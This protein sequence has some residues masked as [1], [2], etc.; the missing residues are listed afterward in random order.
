MRFKAKVCS[1]LFA[2]IAGLNPAEGVDV[3]LFRLLCVV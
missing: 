3:H 2:G 1:R